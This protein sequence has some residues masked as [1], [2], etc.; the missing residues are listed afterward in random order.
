MDA[1]L[2]EGGQWHGCVDAGTVVDVMRRHRLAPS[3][4]HRC[5]AVGDLRRECVLHR[6]FAVQTQFVRRQAELMAY[7]GHGC[8]AYDATRSG[9]PRSECVEG[10]DPVEHD[11]LLSR[12]HEI[13]H[14]KLWIAKLQRMQFG[15]KS[16]KVSGRSNNWSCNWKSWKQ[17][18]LS[19]RRNWSNSRGNQHSSAYNPAIPAYVARASAARGPDP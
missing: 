8:H 18:A 15:R 14:L 5:F 6:Y 3:H 13:E 19:L 4:S 7:S 11:Q 17:S 12:E 2:A 1:S 16:E 9:H 10:V